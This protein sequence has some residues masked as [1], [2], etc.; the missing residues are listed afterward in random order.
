MSGLRPPCDEYR[1]WVT[2][3]SPPV[4]AKTAPNSTTALSTFYK[5]TRFSLTS[6]EQE[7]RTSCLP[8]STP[9]SSY[10][11]VPIESILSTSPVCCLQVVSSWGAPPHGWGCDTSAAAFGMHSTLLNPSP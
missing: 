7:S 9:T 4:R 11:I 6:G 1:S 3:Q 2:Y 10:D 5:D 8:K